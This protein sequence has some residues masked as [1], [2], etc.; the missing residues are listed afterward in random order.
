[1]FFFPSLLWF[2][3]AYYMC[4]LYLILFSVVAFRVFLTVTMYVR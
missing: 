1:V 4:V 3:R 2:P